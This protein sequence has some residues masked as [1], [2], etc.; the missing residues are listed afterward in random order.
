[1]SPRGEAFTTL[2]AT[3]SGGSR[4]V[5]DEMA[6]K[7]ESQARGMATRAELRI[8]FSHDEEPGAS[9]EKNPQ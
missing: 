5:R 3:I 2:S 6:R 4:E 9:S 8:Q 7:I 1:M